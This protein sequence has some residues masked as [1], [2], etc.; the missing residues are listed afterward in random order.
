MCRRGSLNP[1]WGI[2]EEVLCPGL[3]W[4]TA[5]FGFYGDQDPG[6][7]PPISTTGLCFSHSLYFLW[8]TCSFGNRVSTCTLAPFLPQWEPDSPWRYRVPVAL[9]GRGCLSPTPCSLWLRVG[10]ALTFSFLLIPPHLLPFRLPVPLSLQSP[11]PLHCSFMI[12]PCSSFLKTEPKNK[13]QNRTLTPCRPHRPPPVTTS[14]SPFNSQPSSKSI[15][16]ISALP[17]LLAPSDF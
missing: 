6:V 17:Y 8:D 7:P 10:R 15:L 14:L 5:L 13:Q 12:Q 1:V 16:C 11:Q 3:Q 4:N 9:P 2:R